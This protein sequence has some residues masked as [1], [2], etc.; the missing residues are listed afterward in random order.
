MILALLFLSQALSAEETFKTIEETALKA[1][2]LRVV[3]TSRPDPPG[4]S[5]YSFSGT[6]AHKAGKLAWDLDFTAPGPKKYRIVGDGA[7]LLW[8][9]PGWSKAGELPKGF[10][11]LHRLL[12]VRV[13]LYSG[14]MYAYTPYHPGERNQDPNDE[15]SWKVADFAH[16]PDD[17]AAKTL[18][19][20]IW[21]RAAKEPQRMKMIYDPK[22][23]AVLGH[24][25]GKDDEALKQATGIRMDWNTNVDLPDALFKIPEDK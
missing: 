7:R 22:T 11:R 21:V 1:T 20:S 15:A 5:P 4:N 18:H 12:L 19:Y 8:E 13:G 17:G 9:E 14:F 2:S 10:D 24:A 25:Q 23:W 3:C 16:G 6:A